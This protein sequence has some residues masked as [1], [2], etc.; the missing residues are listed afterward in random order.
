MRT[1][2]N[3]CEELRS[4][5]VRSK[6]LELVRSKRL[7]LEHSKQRVLVQVHSKL[8]LVRIQEQVLRSILVLVH[9][10]AVGSS[11]WL[12]YRSNLHRRSR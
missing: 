1:I 9:M 12:A 2:R 8:V 5:L 6:V 10:L 4:K 7:E 3:A 11:L